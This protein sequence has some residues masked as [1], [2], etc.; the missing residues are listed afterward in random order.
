M[1]KEKFLSLHIM[2]AMLYMNIWTAQR[3]P[4]L[5]HSKQR[6]SEAQKARLS[7]EEHRLLSSVS[8]W[9]PKTDSPIR[10]PFTSGYSVPPCELERMCNFLNDSRPAA[11]AVTWAPDPRGHHIPCIW[12][13]ETWKSFLLAPGASPRLHREMTDVSTDR[14]HY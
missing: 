2:V 8:K 7:A 11:Q 13:C 10:E 3:R 14:K 1:W 5:L 12:R 4:F 6:I 9:L